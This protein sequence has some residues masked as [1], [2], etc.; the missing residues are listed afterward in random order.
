MGLA[1][2]EHYRGLGLDLEVLIAGVDISEDVETLGE[3]NTS[4][5]FPVP[6]EYTVGSVSLTLID[7]DGTYSPDNP[8]NFFASQGG[9]QSGIGAAVELKAGFL[10]EPITYETIF[11]GE[12]ART[13]YNPVVGALTVSVFNEM[14]QLYTHKI[15]DFGVARDGFRIDADAENED[16]HGKYKI[17]PWALPFADGSVEVKKDLNA[18]LTEV[19]VLRSE[20]DLSADNYTLVADGIETKGGAI[21]DAATGYPQVEGKSP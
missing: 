4:S 14:H 20:G 10:T 21:E 1:K 5:D 6:N 8:D 13:N 12:I 16:V 3:I 17:A 9:A 19:P 18:V 15:E 2:A 11:K 7:P